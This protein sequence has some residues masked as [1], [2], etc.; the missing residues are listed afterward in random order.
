VFHP[1]PPPSPHPTHTPGKSLKCRELSLQSG[2]DT[3]DAAVN[4]LLQDVA[5]LLQLLAKQSGELLSQH[6]AQTTLPAL[7]LPPQL[8]ASYSS[9]ISNSLLRLGTGEGGVPQLTFCV[10]EDRNSAA[11]Q[12]QLSLRQ[13]PYQSG[14]EP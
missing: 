3:R 1:P 2:M 9:D 14:T 10:G 13:R 7:A 12:I 6:L 4:S 11:R 8:Q 5:T